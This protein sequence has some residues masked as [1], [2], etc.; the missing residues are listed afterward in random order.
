VSVHGRRAMRASIRRRFA[1][2]RRPVWREWSAERTLT[3]RQTA[4]AC[5]LL[6][7]ITS[8]VML[9]ARPVV[10]GTIA[11]FTLVF[12]GTTVLRVVYL[13]RGYRASIRP[14]P[15]AIEGPHGSLPT[16]SVL[17]PIYQEATVVPAL[18]DAIDQL[19]YPFDRLDVILLVEHDDEETAHACQHHIRPGWR[20]VRVPEGH[21]RTKPRA[22]NIGLPL[23]RGEFVTIYD[24]E[25][26]PERD[27]LRKS[28]AEFR[29]S[30]ESVACLQA[31]LDYYN[32]GQN[33]LTKW[34]ACEYA[35]HFGLY[36]EGVADLDHALP[37]GGTSSH[38]RTAAVRAL[39][40][41]DAWNVTEDCELGM[42]LAAAGYR[43]RTLDSVTWEEA[44]PVLWRWVRQR[45]RWVKGFTQTT[46]VMLRSPIRTARGM[47]IRRYLAALASVGG[48]PV[49]LVTQV[50]FWTLLWAYVALRAAGADVSPIEALF[51][52]P[53]LSLGMVSLLVGNFAVLLAHVGVVYQQ[54]RYELVRYAVFMPMYWLLT[55]IGAWRGLA[56]LIH[57]PH[58]WEKTLHGLAVEPEPVASEGST[59]EH[60]LVRPSRPASL[61]ENEPSVVRSVPRQVQR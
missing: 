39:G 5:L 25:D 16:Y 22:L 49:V 45:S 36:L 53:F 60:I 33:L 61:P 58:F 7:L 19:D 4:V 59:R 34:F 26:R 31:R 54:E 52:E 1:L 21:P 10:T 30:S 38:L 13:T 40:G 44:V 24:A 3:T 12:L 8:G 41:W 50:V 57:R 56:Q 43:S 2:E 11:F 47:G 9:D 23:V 42:R 20:I 14:T 46:L 32:A 29:R 51:P 18:L 37:L 28:V 17:V 55:S 35:T 15:R 27:Q 6:A 48:V